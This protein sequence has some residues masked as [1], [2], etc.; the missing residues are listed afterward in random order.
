MLSEISGK[1]GA[2]SGS[3]DRLIVLLIKDI[4]ADVIPRIQ[5]PDRASFLCDSTDHGHVF[6]AQPEKVEVFSQS[7]FAHS[8]GH[9]RRAALNTPG[10]QNLCGRFVVFG[11][12]FGDLKFGA[13]QV[14]I[15]ELPVATRKKRNAKGANPLVQ[16]NFEGTS[17]SRRHIGRAT[18]EETAYIRVYQWPRFVRIWADGCDWSASERLMSCEVNPFLSAK[19]QELCLWEVSGKEAKYEPYPVLADPHTV[20]N[21]TGNVV[22]TDAIPPVSLL[23]GS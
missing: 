9:Y 4:E 23:A 14:L 2:H 20:A 19:L 11:C 12:D 15:Y 17:Q 5:E 8:L 1:T 6:V 22:H 13:S 3:S 16:R 10:E 18:R 7:A 21:E